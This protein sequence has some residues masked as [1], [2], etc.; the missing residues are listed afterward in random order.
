MFESKD[1]SVEEMY[2][3][4]LESQIPKLYRAAIEKR[5]QE[6]GVRWDD[7]KDNCVVYDKE[8]RKGYRIPEK[9]E[10]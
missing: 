2:Q 4:Y 6:L 7:I 8:G 5:C 10:F 1:I 3:F 9:G